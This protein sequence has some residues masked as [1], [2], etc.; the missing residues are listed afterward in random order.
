MTLNKTN[1]EL[2]GG[3]KLPLCNKDKFANQKVRIQVYMDAIDDELFD[4]VI[5]GSYVPVKL[6]P[7]V[8]DPNKLT[9]KQ[10]AE[11]TD[12]ENKLVQLDKKAK[13]ILFMALEDE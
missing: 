3:N 4:I 7:T 13:N 2:G 6:S 12:T 11:W 10:R 1:S 9:V 5:N 8:E